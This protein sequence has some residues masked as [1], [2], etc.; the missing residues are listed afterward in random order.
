MA[1]GFRTDPDAIF[2]CAS[3][4]ERQREEVPRL[5]R[6]LEHVE[7]PQ[8]AFGKLPESDELHASYKEHA[9]AAQQ[10]IHDLAELLRDAA[11]KLR[12][13]A[14]H[15]AANEY[16]TREGFGNGGGSIPA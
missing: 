1:Q 11:E 13:V 5:A 2:R 10:D 9:H 4:T 14:G 7:I 3:G 15:Y 12:A 16:A 6:A 8:G